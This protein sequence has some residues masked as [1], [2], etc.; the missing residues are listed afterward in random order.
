MKKLI[1]ITGATSGI[2][3]ACALK[4]AQ[5]NCDVII[6]GRREKKLNN[7]ASDI[8]NKYKVDVLSLCFDV[9]NKNSVKASIDSLKG[10]WRNIDVLINN[11]GL[12]L[13]LSP[14]Q[15]GDIDDWETMIDTN[16]KG[17]LY[18]SRNIMPLMIKNK[19]GHII[20]IGSI[21]G[22]ETYA[23]GNIYCATKHAVNSITEAMRIDMLKYGVKVTQICPGAVNT[24]FSTVRFKGDKQAADNVYKGFEPLKPEDVA[25]VIFYTTTLPKHVN[26]NDL[27]IMPTMQANSVYFNKKV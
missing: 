17:L 24:E 11:A 2:G 13:G 9:R 10:K 22:K 15:E 19:S 6:T 12:A 7:L 4:F 23:N 5:N 16:V 18:I 20:N 14:I 8:K 21:A 25:D 3:K 27:L 1:F 26:I